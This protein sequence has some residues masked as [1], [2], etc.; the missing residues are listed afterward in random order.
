MFDLSVCVIRLRL[1]AITGDELYLIIHIFTRFGI[2]KN[3][4]LFMSHRTIIT[5][6]KDD[7]VF[8]VKD[9]CNL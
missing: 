8:F 2:K 9:D 4:Y 1:S 6:Q 5:N 3:E 7:V